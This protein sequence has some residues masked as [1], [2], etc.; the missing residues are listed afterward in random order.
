MNDA[1][2]L[3][4]PQRLENLPQENTNEVRR[5]PPIVILLDQIK[6][7]HTQ[8]LEDKTQVLSIY[9]VILQLNDVVLVG[10]VAGIKLHITRGEKKFFFLSSRREPPYLFQNMDFK[11]PLVEVRWAVFHGLHCYQLTSI[12]LLAL[13][14]LPKGAL[15]KQ[16]E[17][18]VPGRCLF[19][20]SLDRL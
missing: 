8:E 12:E 9:E 18:K 3:K 17:N 16:I 6:H 5:K 7:I 11:H 19:V 14:Y 13:D 15:A 4:G 2:L 1:R 20:N 10:I